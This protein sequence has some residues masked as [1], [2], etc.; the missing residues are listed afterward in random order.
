MA[1]PVISTTVVLLA[2]AP[3]FF[4]PFGLRADRLEKGNRVTDGIPEIPARIIDRMQQYQNTRSAWI[5]DWT[6]DGKSL[7]IGTRFGETSQIHIVDEPGGARRQ[8]TFFPEPVGGVTVRPG[9]TRREFLYRKDSAGSEA[10]QLFLFDMHTGRHTMLSDSTSR[11]GSGKWSNKGDRFVYHSTRRNE[12]DW[13]LLLVDME[14]PLESKS[15]LEAGGAWGPVD[16]SPDDRSILVEKYVSV[17]ESYYYILDVET[18]QLEQINPKEERVAYGSARWAKHGRGL[19]IVHDEDSEFHRLKYYDLEIRKFTDLTP[20]IPWDV[21]ELHLSPRGDRLAFTTNEGGISRVYLLDTASLRYEP[22][23][24]LPAGQI[25]GLRFHPDNNRLALGIVTPRTPGDIYVLDLRDGALERWTY[26]EVGGLDTGNFLVPELVN[27][28]TFDR[29]IPCFYYR[30]RGKGPHPVLI[31]IHGGPE[32]QYRPFFRATTQYYVTE[33]GVAVLAPN[34]RGSAGYGKSYL[35]LDNGYK[36]EDS[37][38]DIGALLDWIQTRPE[39]DADRIALMGGSYGGYMVL[40]SMI[41]FGNRIRCGTEAVGISNFVTFL[42]NT[43]GYR[44]DLRR[45]EYGDERDPEMRKFL[46]R[47]SPTSNAHRITR[48]MFVAQGLNDPRVP[49]GESEQIVDA[50]KKNGSQVWYL[51]F[52]DEGHGFRKKQNRDYHENAVALF[53][54]EF[55][56]KE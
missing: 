15:L 5:Y 23:K 30:P 44:R 6:P 18:R 47:I 26:S 16:W 38:R 39:L 33:L 41:R 14:N 50:I 34:V 1:K 21:R 32:I 17:T 40:S 54:E 55:L 24:G 2:F 9:P 20:D 49:A 12:R 3:L 42:E 27:Y 43:K 13:D 45:V 46:T 52:N 7:L 56:L 31:H 36:R 51:L 25:S 10:Y 19:F 37:V 11:N 29:K 53:L 4:Q 22:V 28:P 35:K 8:L 48:P